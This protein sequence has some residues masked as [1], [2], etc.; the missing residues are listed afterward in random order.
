ML[1]VWADTHSTR[2]TK[3]GDWMKHWMMLQGYRAFNMM[4]RKTF[5]KQTTFI[6]PEEKEKQIVTTYKTKRRYLRHAKDAEANDM[7]HMGSD[8]RCVMATFTIN[9]P[10]KN[11]HYKN[12]RRKHDM[13][14]YEERDQAKKK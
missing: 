5:E 14:E 7:I 11:I 3:E 10:G 13:I 12:T 1:K 6:S 4:Y 2:E 9:M 8:H